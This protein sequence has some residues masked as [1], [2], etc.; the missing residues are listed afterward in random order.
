M[1]LYFAGRLIRTRESRSAPV[2]DLAIVSDRLSSV[3]VRRD[4]QTGAV[5]NLAYYPFGEERAATSQNFDKFATY[6][7]DA[8][9]GLDYAR[10]RYYSSQW[11]RFLSAD[12]FGGSGKLSLPQSFNRYT[13]TA[14]DPT[15][16]NDPSGLDRCPPGD[17]FCVDVDGSVD[18]LPALPGWS[19]SPFSFAPVRPATLYVISQRTGSGRRGGP[20]NR[21]YNHRVFGQF[22]VE[23]E[24]GLVIGM[25]KRITGDKVV[26]PV[27]R[28][29]IE[30]AAQT[31]LAVKLESQKMNVGLSTPLV[32]DGFL[33]F[34]AA[35]KS[36][37]LN[38]DGTIAA[39]Q[40]KSVFPFVRKEAEAALSE[41]LSK[42]NI[43]SFLPAVFMLLS[44]NGYCD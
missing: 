8:S 39:S 19:S 29:K 6:Y 12:P 20:R 42:P 44:Q 4:L 26:I 28:G 22:G 40:I 5:T 34:D 41:A 9:T 1:N 3:R 10:N 18:D 31:S 38:L 30:I 16:Y 43:L 24:N 2:V 17:P 35:I 7:R 13:Y 23:C 37:S 14:N 11:A 25:T 27:E 33:F 21:V 32:F 15:N 36:V